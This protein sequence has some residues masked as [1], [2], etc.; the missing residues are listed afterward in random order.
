MTTGSLTSAS[1]SNVLQREARLQPTDSDA[2]VI[3]LVNNMPDAELE[4]TE[5]QFRELLDAASSGLPIRLKLFAVPEVRRSD[6]G[7]AQIREHYSDIANLADEQVD[8]LI[9]TGTEPRARSLTEEPFWPALTRLVDW[10][11]EHTRSTIWSCLAAHMAALYLD[12]IERRPYPKKLLGIFECEKVSDHASVASRPS[13]W[14]VPHSRHNG[15]P[16]DKLAAR[17]YRILSR[18]PEA[19][20]DTFLRQGRSLFLFVQGHP[21]YDR[22]ALHREHRRDIRRFLRGQSDC[23][24]EIPRGYFDADTM[25]VL[26]EF[27]AKAL[28]KRRP[29]LIDELPAISDA[30][31]AHSWRAGAVSL[32]RGWLTYLYAERSQSGLRHSRC[33]AMVGHTGVA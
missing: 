10:A 19:G 3:G 8:G 20:P 17:G 24:P 7:R 9:V 2:L 27:R 33:E 16:E 12:G 6:A 11:E 23:Y 4:N 25:R 29:E 26:E 14:S 30:A 5:I 21:E 31:I 28:Q 1:N 18:S 22:H 13:R 15:L 32:Y